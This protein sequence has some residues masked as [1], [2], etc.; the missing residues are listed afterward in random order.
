MKLVF[1]IHPSAEL[2]FTILLA[3]ELVA[4]EHF[5]AISIQEPHGPVLGTHG[6]VNAAHSYHPVLVAMR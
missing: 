6:R 2:L 3:Q 1:A 5:S 4:V